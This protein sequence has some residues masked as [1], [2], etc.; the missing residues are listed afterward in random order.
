MLFYVSIIKNWYF[1]A[2]FIP[3]S[4][5]SWVNKTMLKFIVIIQVLFFMSLLIFHMQ[6]SWYN[7]VKYTPKDI[8][9][10]ILFTTYM[11]SGLIICLYNNMKKTS[12]YSEV[13]DKNIAIIYIKH[14]FSNQN[15]VKSVFII[16][17]DWKVTC[18]NNNRCDVKKLK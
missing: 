17:K 2:I 15:F 4:L 5:S 7:T 6:Y 16:I 18:L 11:V 1:I 3:D 9:K 13:P 10:Y 8:G 14:L 12:F